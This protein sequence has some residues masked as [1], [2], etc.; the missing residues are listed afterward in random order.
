MKFSNTI[1]LSIIFF[2]IF[3][4]FSCNKEPEIQNTEDVLDIEISDY[5]GDD[6]G[7]LDYT[8]VWHVTNKRILVVF[9]YNFNEYPV[10]DNLKAFLQK[11]FGLDSDGGL[12]YPMIYPENFKH[13][14]RT[15]ATDIFTILSD[16]SFEWAGV[17][18]LGAPENTHH[19]LARLQDLWGENGVPYPVVSLY[20]Q[21][22]VLGLES[23]CNFVIDKG[24]ASILDDT[25]EFVDSDGQYIESVPEILENLIYYFISDDDGVESAFEKNS[26][27]QPLVEQILKGKKVQRYSDPESGIPSINHFVLE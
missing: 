14:G 13:N 23:T 10:T 25:E 5:N 15:V 16:S 24:H 22:D 21:D 12:I 26:T 4:S 20:A 19:G 11:R 1:F 2:S 7:H 17:I 6:Y 27:L 18:L 8:Q 3:V 9:G